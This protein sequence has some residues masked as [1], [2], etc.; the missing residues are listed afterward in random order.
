MH[1]SIE[2][3]KWCKY[4]FLSRI[5]ASILKQRLEYIKHWDFKTKRIV[6]IRAFAGIAVPYSNS[7]LFLFPKLFSGGSNDIRAWQPYSLGPGS[8]GGVILMK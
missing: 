4:Y 6:A 2:K 7:T 1:Q 3:P 8:S 5:F